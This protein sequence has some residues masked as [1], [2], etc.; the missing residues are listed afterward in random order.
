MEGMEGMR[1]WVGSSFRLLLQTTVKDGGV[2]V[3]QGRVGSV[4]DTTMTV[5]F[6]LFVSPTA[7][8]PPIADVAIPLG[9]SKRKQRQAVNATEN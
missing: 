9:G 4:T 6:F 5:S 7:C 3:S 8:L 1:R 2:E